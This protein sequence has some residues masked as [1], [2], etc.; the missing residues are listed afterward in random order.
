MKK[1]NYFIALFFFLP[2]ALHGCGL[3][4]NGTTMSKIPSSRPPQ[5]GDFF[6]SFRKV[7][8]GATFSYFVRHLLRRRRHQK[9]C[10]ISSI[11]SYGAC[12][13]E[14][15]GKEK[16]GGDGSGQKATFRWRRWGRGLFL[17]TW[18]WIALKGWEREGRDALVGS[19]FLNFVYLLDCLLPICLNEVFVG[20][21]FMSLKEKKRSQPSAQENWI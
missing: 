18:Y 20:R 5:E 19:I 4:C 11:H 6:L 1:E 9:K 16:D 14:E 3:T 10:I 13:L 17:R 15:E 8:P 21:C 2:P 12:R 7:L